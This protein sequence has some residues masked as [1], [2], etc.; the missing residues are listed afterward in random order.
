MALGA[1]LEIKQGQQLVMTPQLQQ[2][3]KLLQLSNLELA[4]FVDE[5]LERNPLLAR[6]DSASAN[7]DAPTEVSADAD[8]PQT[9]ADQDLAGDEAGFK[10]SDTFDTGHENLHGDDTGA[11]TVGYSGSNTG[12]AFSVNDWSS[13]G[14]GGSS[15][16][17]GG[18]SLLEATLSN[19]VTL[20]DHLTEQLIIASPDSETRMIGEHLIDYLTD[21]GY[22]PVPLEEA[23]N[24]LG[25]PLAA[26]ERT[27]A[28]VQ[29]FDPPGIFARDLR[30]C[31]ALQLRDRDRFDPAMEALIDNLDLLVKRDLGSLLRICGVDG[32]NLADMIGEIRQ[33]DPKPGNAFGDEV[34]QPV[35]SDVFVRQGQHGSWQIELNS[36]TLPRVLVNNRYYSEIAPKAANEQD[37]TY[38]A[39]CLQ[40]ANWLVKSLDQRARTILKIAGEIVRQQD[41]FFITG[42]A[43]LRPLNL[44]TIAEAIDMHE[45]TISR[46]TAN[47]YIGTERGTFAMKFFFN[48]A[49]A[50]SDGGE[51]HAAESVRQR[52]KILIDAEDPGAI[53][54]DDKIVDILRNDG[55]DIA[56]RT[57]AKYREV[58]NIQ[59]SVQRRWE[60]A[61]VI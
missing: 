40:T 24:R 57:V 19:N 49:I 44:K 52:I 7:R 33:L 25:T 15:G 59:S 56:R 18:E 51:A 9:R 46:V 48:S 2:A 3:I 36:D 1:R 35:V 12:D 20:R 39:E 30:E 50:A 29:T 16:G 55:I 4:N 38:L 11:D 28:L 43:Y 10:N 42:V 60:K 31:L 22:L 6:D 8:A 34:I 41:G 27:L 13:V 5:E 45:S 58:M 32:E 23:A 47:K 54:S 53:L 61:A 26:V 21:A 14:N 37:K 17:G